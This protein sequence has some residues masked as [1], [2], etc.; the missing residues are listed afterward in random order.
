LSTGAALRL[1]RVAGRLGSLG[2]SGPFGA[3]GLAALGA[4]Q[5]VAF[6]HT[7]W[8]PL[9]L[10]AAGVLAAG[11]WRARPGRAFALGWCFG[12]GWLLAGVW[13]L[14]IS[15]HRYGGLAA[16]LAALAVLALAAF[17]SLYLGAAMAAFARWRRGEVGRDALLFAALWLLAELARGVLFTGFPWAASGYAQVDAPLARL[18][19][20]VGVYGLAAVGAG[21]AATWALA[22]RAQRW[23][24]GA[25][26]ASLALAAL[27]AFAPVP[28]FTRAAGTLTVALA[29][30]NVPQDEKFA[31]ARLPQTLAEVHKVLLQASADLVVVPETAVPLL[32]GQLDDLVPGYWQA[33]VDHFAGRGAAATGA[34]PTPRAALVGRPLGDFEHGYTNSVIGLAGGAPYRYDKSHLVPFGEFIPYGFRWFTELMNIPLGDFNRGRP[35]PPPF[36]VLGQRISPNICYED[37]FGE[38]LARRFVPGATAGASGASGS[39]GGWAGPPTLLANLSN[40]GWFGP[41][42]AVDQHLHISRMRTLE[43]QVPMVR[44]T[45]TGATAAITHEGAVTAMLEPYTH[46]TLVAHVEGRAGVTPYASWAGRFGLWP[47]ALAAM[48][49]VAAFAIGTRR[50][51]DRAETE[52][53]P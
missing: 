49:V 6:V 18:A 17:L 48:A 35:D 10:A 25:V 37:L 31:A 7:A 21:L 33:L 14:F 36:V 39:A 50:R 46:G 4:A 22:L 16:P 5:T 32:P 24:G 45:N 12:T 52:A 53:R 51:T 26:P 47:L 11:V 28:A 2:P 41:T 38:E 34:T 40:I 9:P 19:P 23:R 20:W 29:Q 30:T 13:W 1:R 43:F 44:A 42:I 8:W 27:I 3:L 15:M